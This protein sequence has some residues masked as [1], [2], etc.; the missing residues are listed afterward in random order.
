MQAFGI[1][2]NDGRESDDIERL[3][4]NG[5]Y[6]ISAFSVESI[7]YHPKVQRL[8]TVRHAIVT[9][10]DV[11]YLLSQARNAAINAINQHAQRLAERRAEKKVRQKI[12][13]Q[14]PTRTTL[15]TGKAIN[16]QVNV[17]EVVAKELDLLNSA[18]VQQD[19]DTLI[20]RYPVRET[21]TLD[22]IARHLGFQ[23]RNQYEGAVRRMLIDDEAAHRF[24]E[25]LFGT[26]AEDIRR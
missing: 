25:S 24:V 1:I 5:V 11:E 7:Y 8:V 17:V 12:F 14:L 23:N 26:L 15:S 16:I 20:Q 13:E 19:V 4:Q 21:P 18:I 3:R 9:G 2:D 10:D 22:C 6:A